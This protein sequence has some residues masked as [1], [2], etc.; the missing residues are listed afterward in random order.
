MTTFAPYLMPCLLFIADKLDAT[1]FQ[2]KIEVILTPLL[3]LT[4][5]PEIVTKI[6]LNV[7]QYSEVL[8]KKVCFVTAL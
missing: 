4:S 1:V 7:I 2:N 6:Y 5:P 8:V 3:Q